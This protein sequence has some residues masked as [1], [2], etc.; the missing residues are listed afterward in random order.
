[1]DSW[2]IDQLI[3]LRCTWIYGS[4]SKR[5]KMELWWLR[6]RLCAMYQSMAIA[7]CYI[8]L[9]WSFMLKQWYW[10]KECHDHHD[11]V[12][13][14]TW[15]IVVSQFDLLAKNRFLLTFCISIFEQISSHHSL[16]ISAQ[17]ASHGHSKVQ[18]HSGGLQSSESSVSLSGESKFDV[19]I[20]FEPTL[21]PL[22]N[23]NSVKSRAFFCFF[24][25]LL[26][27]MSHHVSNSGDSLTGQ[28][29][30]PGQLSELGKV[31]SG[32][33]KARATQSNRVL[34][35]S[36]VSRGTTWQS[37]D[38]SRTQKVHKLMEGPL[39]D[40]PAACSIMLYRCPPCH[41][42]YSSSSSSSSLFPST[43]D[44]HQQSSTYD[45]H[46]FSLKFSWENHSWSS[47]IVLGVGH[48]GTFWDI[49]GHCGTLEVHR[50]GR[51]CFDA[52]C[53][54]TTCVYRSR[55]QGSKLV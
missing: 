23:T 27:L 36:S 46:Y 15:R 28:N 40:A 43:H 51:A 53:T 29:S 7:A 44:Q 37:Q 32:A 52:L 26:W 20:L 54:S 6:A 49:V 33:K 35:V 16:Q 30:W 17:F 39:L 42:R 11:Q 2:I 4:P 38:K 19:C 5:C 1:M 12:K 10:C 21:Y 55:I 47:L 25:Q 31:S 50:T 18:F 9:H 22:R 13:E 41:Q 48:S 45:S 34:F 14:W 8:V 24:P 3:H